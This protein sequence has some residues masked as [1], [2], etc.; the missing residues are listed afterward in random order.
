MSGPLCPLCCMP[1][2]SERMCESCRNEVAAAVVAM[3][4]AA[5]AFAP[6]IV[7]RAAAAVEGRARKVPAVCEM[8]RTAALEADRASRCRVSVGRN[9]SVLA[10]TTMCLGCAM[11]CLSYLAYGMGAAAMDEDRQC[12]VIWDLGGGMS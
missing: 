5:A 2:A 8:C 10:D 11:C 4:D 12:D 9:A 3:E 7:E 1:S 6:C